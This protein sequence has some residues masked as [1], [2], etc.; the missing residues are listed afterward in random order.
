M[1]M[2]TKSQLAHEQVREPQSV[3]SFYGANGPIDDVIDEVEAEVEIARDRSGR[4]VADH[5]MPFGDRMAD[6][7]DRAAHQVELL[8]KRTASSARSGARSTAQA[9]REHPAMTA[10]VLGGIA[11][12]A[13][14]GVRIYKASK[15][16]P[17]PA[18]Q[19]SQVAP[20]RKVTAARPGSRQ[21]H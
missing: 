20:K 13:Y 1:T 16:E 12:A 7:F 15:S 10:A 18:K 17:A 11:T 14:A 5:A 4:F 19:Q 9:V 2:T 3:S 8:A 21:K 6:Q